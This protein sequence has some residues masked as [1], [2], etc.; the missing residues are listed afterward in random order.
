MEAPGR[1]SIWPRIRCSSVYRTRAASRQGAACSRGRYHAVRRGNGLQRLGDPCREEL[2]D[3]VL[4]SR[5]SGYVGG[6][7]IAGDVGCDLYRLSS[8]QAPDCADPTSRDHL[9][10]TGGGAAVAA[11]KRD[12]SLDQVRKVYFTAAFGDRE[13]G[14]GGLFGVLSGK[15]AE[16][17]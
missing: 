8:L 1:I 12:S 2:R 4:L 17:D 15:T 3:S 6:T 9:C 16:G 5:S 7:G 13:T 10:A 14:P 11:N